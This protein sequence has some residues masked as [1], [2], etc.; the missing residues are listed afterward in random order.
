MASSLH[1]LTAREVEATKTPGRL[2]DGG[3]LYLRI[4]AA[5]TRTWAFRSLAG[6]KQDEVS[7][8][9]ASGL[10]LAAARQRA[11]A[12]R[13]RMADGESLRQAAGKGVASKNCGVDHPPPE[14]AMI[15]FAAYAEAYIASVEAGWRNPIH[16]QQWR[17]TLRDHAA[18]LSD[19][20]ID[21]ISTDD[22]L[23][24]LRPIWFTKAETAK[25]LRGRI[26]KVLDAAKAN[27]LRAKD[28]TNPAA[29][30]GHLAVLL[31]S[32]KD[33]PRSNH[34][35][36]PW[37]EAPAFWALLRTREALSARCLEFII[38]TAARSGEALGATW[39]EIDLNA[40]LWT[41]PETRMKARKEHEVPLS[42]AAVAILTALRPSDAAPNN[43]V[44]AVAGVA[45][46]NMAIAMLLR[47]M[48]RNDLT[49]H[50]FRST[51]R[52]WAGD[53]TEYASELI[54]HALAHG[55]KDKAQAAYRRRTARERRRGLMED[56]AAYLGANDGLPPSELVT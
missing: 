46:S 36:L 18:S 29:W 6:G 33:V 37:E 44:F 25:R 28:S 17:Q 19:K 45:R 2:A 7:L 24:V 49:T 41:V 9:L 4:T 35:A 14:P 16:R 31:P 34:A 52:D 40:K 20:A 21:A 11:A 54:E 1:R 27:G 12:I 51:F 38:L 47:R 53:K 3:G 55:I 30:R 13:Q 22:V 15:T 42:D 26:E 43:R 50:G 23:A 8:G 56:W 48:G 5:G 32:Q 10:T 39:Q